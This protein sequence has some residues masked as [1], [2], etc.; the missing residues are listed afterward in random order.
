MDNEERS[1][2]ASST[3]RLLYGDFTQEEYKFINDVLVGVKERSEGNTHISFD[4]KRLIENKNK[5]ESVDDILDRTFSIVDKLNSGGIKTKPY[6]DDV[7][8]FSFED[9]KKK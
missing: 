6:T 4:F 9:S 5:G 2:A 7:E 3:F 1:N 8:R